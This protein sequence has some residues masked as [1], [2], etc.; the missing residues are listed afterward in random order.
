MEYVVLAIFAQIFPTLRG[1]R[2]PRVFPKI[3]GKK[4]T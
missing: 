3:L 2:N 1:V 4:I